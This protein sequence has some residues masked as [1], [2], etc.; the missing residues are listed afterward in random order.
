MIHGFFGLKSGMPDTLGHKTHLQR[1]Y[2]SSKNVSFIFL[3]YMENYEVL[4]I[5]I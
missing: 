5:V 4:Y 3:T 1:K 2:P